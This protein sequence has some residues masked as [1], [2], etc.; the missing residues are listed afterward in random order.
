MFA[1]DAFGHFAPGQRPQQHADKHGANQ[2][3][4]GDGVEAEVA[5][6]QRR[7]VDDDHHFPRFNRE[8]KKQRQAAF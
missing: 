2:V 7:G 8:D 4:D 6:D 1:A 5:G 3:A